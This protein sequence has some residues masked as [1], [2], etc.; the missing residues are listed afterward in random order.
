MNNNSLKQ[1][2]QFHVKAKK[3]VVKIKTKAKLKQNKS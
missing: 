1:V 2:T 3:K